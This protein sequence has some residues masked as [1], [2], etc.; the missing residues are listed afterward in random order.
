MAQKK[1]KRV[2]GERKRPEPAPVALTADQQ[3]RVLAL[4]E[5]AALSASKNVFGSNPKATEDLLGLARWIIG[6]DS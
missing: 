2:A 4:Q 3:R 5:A 6:G 1:K